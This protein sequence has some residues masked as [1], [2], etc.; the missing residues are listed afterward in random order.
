MMLSWYL[1]RG[2]S[3]CGINDDPLSRA[4]FQARLT[5]QC[6]RNLLTHTS[7]L[8]YTKFG[9]L[10]LPFLERILAPLEFEPGEGFFYGSK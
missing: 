2:K 4:L 6:D 10:H 7:G 9:Q 1:R 8:S 3:R 5:L